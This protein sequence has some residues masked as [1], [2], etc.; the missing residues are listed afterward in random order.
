[1]YLDHQNHLR[2]DAE[3]KKL[4]FLEIIH[5]HGTLLQSWINKF[6]LFKVWVR[7]LLW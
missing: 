1:M 6:Y 3:I 7:R 2:K 5:I 4:N